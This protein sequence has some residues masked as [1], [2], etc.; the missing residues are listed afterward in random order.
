MSTATMANPWEVKASSGGGGG[1]EAYVCPAGNHVGQIT[2]LVHAGTVSNNFGESA[3]T[4]ILVYQL[5]KKREDGKPYVLASKYTY[6]LNT[7]ANFRKVVESVVGRTLAD[8]EAFDPRDLVGRTV[9]VSVKN[10]PSKD[11][12]RM[13]DDVGGVSQLPEGFPEPSLDQFPHEPFVWSVLDGTPF[14]AERA[15]WM[16]WVYG[17]SIQS[18]VENSAEV[19]GRQ[20]KADDYPP[21]GRPG[22]AYKVPGE[23]SGDPAF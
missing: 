3:N 22:S 7:K 23:D 4:I 9:L 5:L 14:P 18:I 10:S 21:P 15:G 6:S 2:G 16:P 12:S 11:G 17:H 19:R 1:G 13:Y 8:G 20:G